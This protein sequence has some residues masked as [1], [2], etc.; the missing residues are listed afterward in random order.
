MTNQ[1]VIPK[2]T[3]VPVAGMV[4]ILICGGKTFAQNAEIPLFKDGLKGKGDTRC[5]MILLL[6]Q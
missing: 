3:N 4:F 1:R 6:I 5:L 2:G